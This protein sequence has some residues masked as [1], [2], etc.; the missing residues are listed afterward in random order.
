MEPL[1]YPYSYK[2]FFYFEG[3]EYFNQKPKKGIQFLQ[4][5]GVLKH[6]LDVDEVSRFLRENPALNKGMIGEYVS[7]RSNL[8]ILDAFVKTF[9]F[10]GVR[11]DE[12]LRTFLESFR[13]P[14][15]V[16]QFIFYLVIFL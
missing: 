2:K 14:G 4:E 15:N 13:L 6:E 16:L 3:T 8:K 7:N 10:T 12:A 11:I 5:H 1:W 9:S